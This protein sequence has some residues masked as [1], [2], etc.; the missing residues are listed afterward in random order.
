MQHHPTAGDSPLQ[1]A[2]PLPDIKG[3]TD[4]VDFYLHDKPVTPDVDRDLL[5]RQT[6]GGSVIPWGLEPRYLT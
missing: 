5:A 2:V 6:Q 4:L 1:V 3:R